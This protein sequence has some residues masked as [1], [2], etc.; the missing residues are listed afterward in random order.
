GVLMDGQGNLY[1]EM[2]PGQNHGGAGAELSPG[3]NGWVYTQL[4]SF[5]NQYSCPDGS[6][7]PGPPIW[8]GKGNLFGTTTAGGIGQPA[9]WISYGCGV[10][11]EM[12]PN[13]D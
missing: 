10:V 6:G 12:T 9:C 8:D 5:C 2:G 13:G 4:Y 1:G 7:P 11:Y 3:S